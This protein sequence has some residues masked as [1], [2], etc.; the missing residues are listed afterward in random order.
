[1]V[2]PQG[3]DTG[4]RVLRGGSWNCEPHPCRSA[5][6]NRNEPEYSDNWIG[7][8]LCFFVE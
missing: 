6:R 3:P 8:R 1:V 7:F 5:F 2:D 4:Y